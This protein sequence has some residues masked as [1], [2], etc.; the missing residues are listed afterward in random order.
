MEGVKDIYQTR[1]GNWACISFFIHSV[2]SA[3]LTGHSTYGGLDLELFTE[4]Q[5]QTQRI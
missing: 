4:K 5:N 2:V 1:D 3:L